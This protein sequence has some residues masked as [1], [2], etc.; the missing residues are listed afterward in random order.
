MALPTSLL[1]G[2][3]IDLDHTTDYAWYALTGDHRLILPLHGYEVAFPLWLVGRHF[4]GSRAAAAV[5]ASYWMHLLSDELENQTTPGAYWLIR[6]LEVGFRF[7]AL[8]RNPVAAVRGRQEDMDKL[9]R[10]ARRLLE[11]LFSTT[12]RILSCL[13]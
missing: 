12:S 2:T 9:R 1:V 4:L 3:V 6:R 8:S 10:L 11:D 7:E 5:V 13:G